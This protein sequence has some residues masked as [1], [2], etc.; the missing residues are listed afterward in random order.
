MSPDKEISSK[1]LDACA[2]EASRQAVQSAQ[3]NKVPYTVQEGRN[4]VQHQTDGTKKVVGTLPKA[5]VRPLSKSY[6]VA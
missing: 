4:I 6:R 5:Y 2:K 1:D 3:A